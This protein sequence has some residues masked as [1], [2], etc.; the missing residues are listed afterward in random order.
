MEENVK[1]NEAEIEAL[2]KSLDSLHA[3]LHKKL[4]EPKKKE[5]GDECS[6]EEY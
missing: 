3:Y 5:D 4:D 6:E 1:K 2:K